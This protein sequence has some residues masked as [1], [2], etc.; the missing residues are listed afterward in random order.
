MNGRIVVVTGATGFIGKQLVA[1]LLRAGRTVVA[2]HRRA[3]TDGLVRDERLLWTSM[4]D[5]A[6]AFRRHRPEA[7]FHLATCYGTDTTLAEVVESNLVMPLGL[8]EL[9]AAN[10]CGLFVN[11]DTFFGKPEFAYTHMRP[12]IRSKDEFVRW[13][14]LARELSRGPT[15]V[16]ARLEHV[17][18]PGDGEQKFVSMLLRTLTE[19]KPLALTPG[20]QLRDFVHVDDVVAA[21]LAILDGQLHGGPA[22]TEIEVGTGA[23]HSLRDF[24]ETAAALSGSTSVLKFGAKPHR[25]GEIMRSF[26]DTARLRALGWRARHDLESGIGATLTAIGQS[27]RTTDSDEADAFR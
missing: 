16:T 22:V 3:S 1:A 6:E 12:Y 27:P 17:Y 5:A 24:V 21:Y 9:A 20:D 14:T 2:L 10:G 11:T 26:A 13:A 8:L 4:A 15:L 7:V 18:G 19:N 23:V 25:D